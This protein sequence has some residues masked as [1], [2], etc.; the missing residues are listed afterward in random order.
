MNFLPFNKFVKSENHFDVILK[1]LK[2][3]PPETRLL[4]PNV[5]T[6]IHLLLT[7]SATSVTPERS[8]SVAR[9]IKA[10]LTGT[11]TK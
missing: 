11:M 9:R 3:T 4:F 7:N 2:E 8:F 6:V 10:W 5:M 1:V